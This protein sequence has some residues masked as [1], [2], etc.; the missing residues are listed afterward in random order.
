MKTKWMSVITVLAIGWMPVATTAAEK[1]VP[2]EGFSAL[3]NGKDFTGWRARPQLNPYKEAALSAEE[4]AKLQAKWDKDFAAHWSIENGELVNDGKGPYATTIEDFGDMILLLEYKT[5]PKADSGIYLRATPQVQI[6]DTTKEGGK[7]ER[8]ANKGSGGLFN[9]K[10]HPK[11][12]LVLADKPHGK[13]NKFRIIQTGAITTVY[14]NGKLV[15]DKTVMENFW[16]K[17]WEKNLPLI[18]E[19][20]IQFQTHGGEIRFR[21][22]FVKRLT[23][24]QA[25]TRLK[26]IGKEGFE[27]VFNGKDFTGWVGATEGYEVLKGGVLACKKGSGGNIFLK[28]E[29]AGFHMRFMFKLPPGANNGLA[30]WSPI[31]GNPAYDG[32]ELQILDDGHEKYKNLKDWQVH[33]SVYGVVPAARGYLR[34]TGEWNFEEVIAK[35]GKVKVVVNGTTIVDTDL[36]KIEKTLHGKEV[37][38]MTHHKGHIGFAGHNDA[39]QFKNIQ[40]KRLD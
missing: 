37:K 17:D 14:M 13:W 12:P 29:Y 1:N 19:G 8:G 28:D 26:N 20:P 32:L 21:N 40:I 5:V 10:T 27:T 30:V 11:D 39:V 4:K 34:P 36:T 15:V 3:F 18:K 38:G 23:P 2:P 31:K 7:W 35:D 33:G 6:W 22:V 24:Q 16:N 9:N 25:N